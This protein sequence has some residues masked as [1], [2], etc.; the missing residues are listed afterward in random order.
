M[1]RR[2]PVF[3]LVCVLLTGAAFS[4]AD[5][6][7][8]MMMLD[9]NI[10]TMNDQARLTISVTGAKQNLPDP[11]L[12]N[13]SMFDVIPQGT[14][15]NI[16]IINGEVQTT[17]SLTYVLSPRKTGAFVIRPAA[18]IIDHERYQSEELTLKVLDSDPTASSSTEKE[19]ELSQ[20][21]QREVFLVAEVDKEEAYVNEQI[22]LAIKF[23]HA[24][25]LYSQPDYTP[26]QTT[27]FW[28]D[29]LEPQKSYYEMVGDRRYKVVEINTALFPTR[30]GELSIGRAMIQ[31]QVP[32]RR[33]VRGNDPFSLFDNFF[34]RGET[35]TI[36]SKP[37]EVKA[38]PL[39]T[40]N[41]PENFSGTVGSF[42]I[43]AVADKRNVDVNEPITVTY[44]IS[45]TG[46]IK[47]V[48]E[49]DIGDLKDFRVYRAS[50]SEK[51]S[52]ING[53]VGGTKIFEEVFIPNRAGKL[54]IPGVA[55][56][57][58]D[59]VT[60]RYKTI[61]TEDIQLTVSPVESE[62]YAEMPFRPVA[63]RVVDPN[64][65]DIRY[66]KTNA[67]LRLNRSLVVFSPL[68]LALNG[69]PVV[70]LIALLFLRRRNDR[71]M[72]DV[73]YARARGAKKMARKRLS[74]ARQL[75]GSG[76]GGEFFG[77]IRL[78]LFAYVAD[79]AGISPHG[80]SSE[81]LLE[82]IRK[83]GAAETLIDKTADLLRQADFAR[84]SSLEVTG[85]QMEDAL[86]AAEEVLM[87]MEALKIG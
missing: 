30:P 44:R 17:K 27:D 4:A 3:F 36:R 49:P 71:L 26:P 54:I 32:T 38:R 62:D 29:M 2:V 50:S 58:F 33:R 34:P 18:V 48:A 53:M 57:F 81:Q 69:V 19:A 76:N 23:Y 56:N 46:N 74:R 28:T 77:E 68:Y 51:V 20:N 47:T 82:I 6:V 31:V 10:I 84:Y 13:L 87:N 35:V 24:V 60:K 80:M 59:P 64:A 1:V 70:L 67:D 42:K 85:A 79:K 11:E 86:R 7:T 14:S 83:A 12:P 9:R 52:K 78:A 8:V 41:K 40:E 63:G 75:A 45:G 22:T 37:L 72:N 16:S 43:T 5:E 39:P 25:N 21:R 61:T 66:I 73:R 65:K 55:F 15:T